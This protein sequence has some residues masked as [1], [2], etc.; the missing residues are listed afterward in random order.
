MG[1][2][3]LFGSLLSGGSFIWVTRELLRLLG[4]AI[5][6]V[7]SYKWNLLGGVGGSKNLYGSLRECGVEVSKELV[8]EALFFTRSV[9]T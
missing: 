9:C 1:S 2:K 7:F 4:L 3:N 5:F 6:V 8:I